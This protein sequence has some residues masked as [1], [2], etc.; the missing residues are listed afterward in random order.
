MSKQN[1]I[2]ADLLR[3]SEPP[4]FQKWWADNNEKSLDYDDPKDLIELGW[5]AA[6]ASLPRADSPGVCDFCNGRGEVDRDGEGHS[7]SCL[8]C[9]GTGKRQKDSPE[10]CPM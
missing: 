1:K 8:Y 2:N 7:T 3:P 9:D 10:K 4:S 5:N 6:L